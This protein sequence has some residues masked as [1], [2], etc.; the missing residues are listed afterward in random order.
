VDVRVV[1]ATNKDL[2]VLVS[3]GSFREDL[4]YRIHVIHLEIPRLVDRREDIPLLVDHLV[5]KFNL[6]QGKEVAGASPETLAVLME[7]DYP[8]NVRELQNILE[9][10]FVLCPGGLIEAEHLPPYLRSAPPRL[11][12]HKN[13]EMDLRSSERLIITEAL[14]RHGGHRARTA[15]ELGIDPSTL[16]R[17]IKALGI[18]PPGR[19]GRTRP[20]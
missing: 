16:Y 1:A 5:A 17:K 14:E 4:F 8:G 10:A 15:R 20:D 2:S 19:D 11:L 3:Q 13:D 12:L 7:H 9:H 6:L 18:A